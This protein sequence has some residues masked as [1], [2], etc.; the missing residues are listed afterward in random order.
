MELVLNLFRQ[1]TLKEQMSA[2]LTGPITNWASIIYLHP[3]PHKVA[4]KRM[5]VMSKS[6]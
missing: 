5:A 4:S 6:P 3:A 1:H 2:I